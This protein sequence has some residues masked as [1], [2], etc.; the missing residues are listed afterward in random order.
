L[1]NIL[2]IVLIITPKTVVENPRASNLEYERIS[3]RADEKP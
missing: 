3:L 2:A 1:P